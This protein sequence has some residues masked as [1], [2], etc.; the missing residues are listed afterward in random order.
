MRSEDQG[1]Q[2]RKF[3]R[4]QQIWQVQQQGRKVGFQIGSLPL[5]QLQIGLNRGMSLRE[6]MSVNEHNKV[7]QELVM[8]VLFLSN[9]LS[10]NVLIKLLKGGKWVEELSMLSMHI[11]VSNATRIV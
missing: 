1:W 9:N 8:S 5:V 3:E 4:Q 7:S 2:I 11:L 6:E 10:L